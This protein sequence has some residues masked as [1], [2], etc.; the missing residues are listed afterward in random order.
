MMD[1]AKQLRK[2]HTP[3]W[4]RR[5]AKVFD[6]RA[7]E[8]SEAS[9]RGIGGAIARKDHTIGFGS[10]FTPII[11]R[12]GVVKTYAEFTEEVINTLPDYQVRNLIRK[13]SPIVAKA[14]ADYADA[15]AS[16]YTVTADRTQ[17]NVPDLP[18]QRLLDD[19]LVRMADTGVDMQQLL[20]ESGRGMFSHGAF[21]WE[22][23]IDEDETTPLTIKNLDPTTAVFRRNTDP[24]L[25]EYYELG[26][27]LGFVDPN[28]SRART[29]V[30]NRQFGGGGIVNFLSLHEDPT[31]IYGPVQPEANNPYGIPLLDPAVFHVIIMAGFITAFFQSLTGAVWPNRLIT[32]DIEK[33]KANA[34]IS[35]NPK[36][37]EEK[38]N[39]TIEDIMKN[40]KDLKPGGVLVQ[41]D[42]VSIGGILTGSETRSP[43]GS[44]K[45]IQDV[46]RRELVIAVQSQPILLGSNEAI[47]E[48]HAIEQIKAYGKLIRRGQKSINPRMSDLLN[49]ILVLNGYPPLAEFRL[50]YENTADYKDQAA[51]FKLFRE[52][53]LTGSQ[54]LREFAESLQIVVEAGFMTAEQA[55]EAWDEGMEIRRQ[56]NVIPQDL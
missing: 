46:L 45:D 37:L 39:A 25:G 43:L 30:V 36:A 13:S 28:T 10:Y 31:I 52:G 47:A 4:L 34:G 49:L 6:R 2:V 27:D 19:F 48:T 33:F 1:F 51:T 24:V 40:V 50:S 9:T 42:E 11:Q 20:G 18:A 53:L 22:L 16:G 35:K 8:A 29:Q 5:A 41:G 54:D 26:Q 3:R 14:L 7:K 15:I 55:Q 44:V 56:V 38:L 12:A 32:L 21:F 17:P 23:V